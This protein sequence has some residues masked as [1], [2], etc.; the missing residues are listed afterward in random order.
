VHVV[1]VLEKGI[2]D[3]THVGAQCYVSRDAEPIVDIAL[4]DA[5]SG[6]SMTTDT[7][8]IWFSMTK[9][10]TS[11]AVAQ[12][13]ERGMLRIDDRVAQYIPEFASRGKDRITVRHLLTHTAGI[14]NA[15][16]ILQGVPW[17]ESRDDNLARIYAAPLEDGWVPG[18]RAGYHAAAGMTVLGEVVARTS[19]VPFDRYVRAEIFEPLGMTDCWVGMPRERYDA[20]GERIGV[21]HDTSG[22]E[23]RVVGG[24]DSAW[25]AAAPMPGAN[26]RGPVRQLA[27][28]YEAL[29]G[30]G[31]L[32]NVRVLRPQTVA[33][34]SA[35]HRVG[36]VD[37]TFGIVLDWGLGF[38]VDTYITGRHSSPRA[39]GH[40]GHQSSAAFC[41]PEHGVVVAVVCNGMPGPDRHHPRMDAI[42]T[43][44]FVDAGVAGPN[45]PG[46]DKPYP[47]TSP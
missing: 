13:W 47:N 16:G 27:R 19:G 21:M 8:M 36:M 31:M 45:D 4:G 6:V 9:A 15:D 28:F 32:D 7:L 33:A 12:Q 30:Q 5:R 3:G 26:G 17:R 40:G 35:R 25:S 14:P 18:R 24:V 1:E 23:P 22:G 11:V 41:D 46:R 29:L 44:A 39:F 43:A 2:A 42:A 38:A 20:Y 10:V 37:E 34:I